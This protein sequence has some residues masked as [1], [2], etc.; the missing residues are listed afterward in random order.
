LVSEFGGENGGGVLVLTGA[1]E[2]HFL[3]HDEIWDAIELAAHVIGGRL[4]LTGPILVLEIDGH[5]VELW[6]SGE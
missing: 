2:H 1:L 6:G 5:H 4:E 3:A